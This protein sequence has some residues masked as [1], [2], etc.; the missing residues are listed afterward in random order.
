V[1][2]GTVPDVR[3]AGCNHVP[4]LEDC[5]HAVTCIPALFDQLSS[6]FAAVSTLCYTRPYG[7][8]AISL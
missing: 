1:K 7:V 8:H 6:G 3:L 2:K 4:M 5:I